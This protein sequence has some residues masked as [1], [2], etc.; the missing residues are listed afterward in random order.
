MRKKNKRIRSRERER[1]SSRK[2]SYPRYADP[3]KQHC[4]L[5]TRVPDPPPRPPKRC[6]SSFAT[7]RLELLS[8]CKQIIRTCGDKCGSFFFLSLFFPSLSFLFLIL[9]SIQGV[10]DLRQRASLF[11]TGISLSLFR[12]SQPINQK[13]KQKTIGNAGLQRNWMLYT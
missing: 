5:H 9:F 11:S 4:T 6:G 12:A 10:C 2:K 7:P 13:T 1:E 3:P 8:L